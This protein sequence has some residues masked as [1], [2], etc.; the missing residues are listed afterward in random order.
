MLSRLLEVLLAHLNPSWEVPGTQGIGC[1]VVSPNDTA[2]LL[3][4]LQTLRHMSGPNLILTA[5]VVVTTFVGPDGKPLTDVTEFG[6]VLDYIG[7]CFDGV[8]LKYDS[9]VAPQKF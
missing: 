2:N 3:S 6:Q 8:N 1:N 4:F 5:A 9:D 7:L